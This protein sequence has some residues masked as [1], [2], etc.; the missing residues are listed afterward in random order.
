M[1]I[2][3]HV[4]GAGR[5]LKAGC[6]AITLAASF[7]PGSNGPA[8]AAGASTPGFTS[9]LPIYALLPEGLYFINQTTSSWRDVDGV[10]VRVNA[11]IL[12][13]YYQSPFQLA[14]GDLSFVFAP[15]LLDV[16]TSVGPNTKGFYN[17]YLAAQISWPIAEGLRFGYRIGGYVPQDNSVSF[18]YGVIEQ[19]AGFT[20]L[21]DGWSILGNFMYGKPVG[22]K[23]IDAA[24]DYFLADFHVAHTIGKWT[25]GPVAHVS[26]DLNDPI[27]GYARQKQF[28]AGG[29]VA[30]DFGGATLQVKLTYDLYQK[31]YGGKE[32]SLWTNLVV[33]LWTAP[34][35]PVVAKY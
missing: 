7:M 8:M 14:G 18:D 4:R 35:K 32:T 12:F 15:T 20:Y 28:A 16:S 22:D 10:D 30:Y 9:G 29:L 19:R 33:P 31:N 21:K 23:R 26:A 25:I 5:A 13:F 24:P 6:A 1:T 3:N 27:R 2:L 11:D 34:A 17:T